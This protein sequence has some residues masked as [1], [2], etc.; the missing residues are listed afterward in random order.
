[1]D[2]EDVVYTHTHTHTHTMEYYSAIKRNKPESVLVRWMNPGPV[3]Q[4]EI[5]QKEEN[6]HH[7]LTHVYGTEK[8]GADEPICRA[9]IETQTWRMDLWAQ[10][11]M[12]RVR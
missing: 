9:A 1:M 10:W 11:Q 2:K 4:S 5:S 8:N 7:I 6:K 12:E 3:V